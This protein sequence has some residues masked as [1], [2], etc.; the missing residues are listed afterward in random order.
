MFVCDRSI[1]KDHGGSA[2]DAA[3]AAALCS[4]VVNAH[5]TSIGGGAIIT[6]YK[7]FDI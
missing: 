2:M 7:R 5:S 4:S 6:F 3:I 1:M